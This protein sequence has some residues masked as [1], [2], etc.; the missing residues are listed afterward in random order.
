[1]RPANPTARAARTNVAAVDEDS[2]VGGRPPTL[3]Q[4][5]RQA[6]R[7]GKR[8]CRR[9]ERRPVRAAADC[10][11]FLPIMHFIEHNKERPGR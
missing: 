3:A 8:F 2:S 4:S 1:M 5:P 11:V 9:P 10:S 6:N 7:P